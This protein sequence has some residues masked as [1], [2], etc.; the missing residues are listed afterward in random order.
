M[1]SF[2]MTAYGA[3]LLLVI[4]VAGFVMMFAPERAKQIL[5]NAA[6]S[7]ALFLLGWMLVNFLCAALWHAAG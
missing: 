5:K 2:V 1:C 3:I 7:L 6:A 4:V